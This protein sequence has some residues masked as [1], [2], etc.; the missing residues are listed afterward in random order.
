MYQQ[1]TESYWNYVQSSKQAEFDAIKV[2]KIDSETK[3][4][5]EKKSKRRK[6]FHRL[7]FISPC[8][9]SLFR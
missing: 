3:E 9:K 5:N 2:H 7:T 8:F 6:L 1:I 4:D